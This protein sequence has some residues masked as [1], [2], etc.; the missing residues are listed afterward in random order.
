MYLFFVSLHCHQTQVLE[1]QIAKLKEKVYDKLIPNLT[2]HNNLWRFCVF[3]HLLE[4]PR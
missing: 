3:I 1:Q 2:S 4:N